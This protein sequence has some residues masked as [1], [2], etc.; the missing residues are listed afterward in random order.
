MLPERPE[1]EEM[2]GKNDEETYE[3]TIR[4][5]VLT[6]C[7]TTQGYRNE[8]LSKIE[9]EVLYGNPE[10][11]PKQEYQGIGKDDSEQRGGTTGALEDVGKRWE[12]GQG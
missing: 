4:R 12:G 7:G 2:V 1:S 6:S 10:H 8:S 5:T 9:E 3:H 11:Q